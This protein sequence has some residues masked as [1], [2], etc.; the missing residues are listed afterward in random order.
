M[1]SETDPEVS[2]LD[3]DDIMNQLIDAFTAQNGRAPN[4][5]EV[6]QWG[7][8][9]KAALAEGLVIGGGEGEALD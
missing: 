3:V 1:A 6:K 5:D 9:L 4:A 7:E 2:E 8:E